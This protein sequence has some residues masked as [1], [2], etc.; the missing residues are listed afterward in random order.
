M[1]ISIITVSYNSS[2]TIAR[3]IKSVLSQENV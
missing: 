3:T 1:K 2:K